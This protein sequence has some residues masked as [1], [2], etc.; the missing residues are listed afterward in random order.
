[1]CVLLGKDIGAIEL[2]TWEA[3][4]GGS[5]RARSLRTRLQRE[6]KKTTDLAYGHIQRDKR[7]GLHKGTFKRQAERESRHCGFLETKVTV[8]SLDNMCV[9]NKFLLNGWLAG[10]LDE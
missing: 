1:M 2:V 4:G 10:W 8:S 5:G 9:F 6:Q 7:K 3:R